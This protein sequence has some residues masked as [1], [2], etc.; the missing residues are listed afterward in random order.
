MVPLATVVLAVAVFAIAGAVYQ[1]IG[2]ARDI[3]RFPP[4]GRLLEFG[5]R[6]L[7]AVCE[8]SGPPVVLESAIAASS[9]SWARVQPLVARFARVCAYDRAGLAWSEA[10]R[11][12]SFARIVADL[13]ALI[14]KLDCDGPCVLVGHSFGVFVCLAYA[15]RRPQRVVGLVLVDPPSE[16]MK[17]DPRQL[18]MMRGG[19]ICRGSEGYSRALASCVP[20]WRC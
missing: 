16:W 5:G 2:A 14:T 3:R 1:S 10:S 11:D 7:H 13:D 17:L 4:P 18:R 6:R 8:G 9:L 19:V 20:V 12:R 15:A